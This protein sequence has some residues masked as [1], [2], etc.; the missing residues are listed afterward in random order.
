[1]LLQHHHPLFQLVDLGIAIVASCQVVPLCNVQ[2]RLLLEVRVPVKQ[3]RGLV[4]LHILLEEL[5]QLVPQVCGPAL[6][7]DGPEN[8]VFDWVVYIGERVVLQK[9][10]RFRQIAACVVQELLKVVELAPQ[11]FLNLL[12][13]AL[14]H[15]AGVNS[16]VD[17]Q[18]ELKFHCNQV[19]LAHLDRHG[20][21][22]ERKELLALALVEGLTHVLNGF[23]VILHEVLAQ[24]PRVCHFLLHG[25]DRGGVAIAEQVLLNCCINVLLGARELVQIHLGLVA[26]RD[27]R[28][29]RGHSRVASGRAVLRGTVA[30]APRVALDV[31]TV[32]GICV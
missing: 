11:I 30:N 5:P 12:R 4:F 16:E 15:K 17:A 1:M 18:I 8:W 28:V 10:G 19:V 21:V 25:L 32:V 9:L 14:R 27:R 20:A 3:L 26:A 7:T 22:P 29:R 24:T 6:G 23:L 31:A 2:P 13:S